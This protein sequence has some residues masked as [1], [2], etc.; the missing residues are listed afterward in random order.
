MIPC[1]M[2]LPADPTVINAVLEGLVQGDLAY[3][4]THPRTPPLASCGIRYRFE[5]PGADWWFIPDVLAT[6]CG[7][8][9]DLSAWRVAE[10]RFHGV[11][12]GARVIVYQTA[13]DIYHAIVERT[14]GW[15]E[16][17]SRALG[18]RG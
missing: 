11:D 12:P 9:K 2:R 15:H 14:G 1:A 8:C 10:L 5:L 6:K 13:R 16:D 3:L 7:D 17:P 18:M 4:K